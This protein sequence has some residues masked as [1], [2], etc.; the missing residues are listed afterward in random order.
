MTSACQTPTWMHCGLALLTAWQGRCGGALGEQLLP[1][2]E[3]SSGPS[4]PEWSGSK[5]ASILLLLKDIV[6]KLPPM[7]FREYLLIPVR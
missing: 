5:E 7:P 4:P 2:Q 3:A 1:G 6:K